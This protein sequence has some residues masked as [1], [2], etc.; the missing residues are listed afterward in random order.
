[1]FGV[2]VSV[3]A[4][5]EVQDAWC[6][7]E[8][9]LYGALWRSGVGS[10]YIGGN[11]VNVDAGLPVINVSAKFD[12]FIDVF[13]IGNWVGSVVASRIRRMARQKIKNQ[14]KNRLEKVIRAEVSVNLDHLLRSYLAKLWRSRSGW[15]KF[16]P[17]CQHPDAV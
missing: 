10:L 11:A 3:W 4:D 9:P 12:G 5:V 8:I 1:M 13:N 16:D 17:S 15:G 7:V 2:A 6:E 14:L